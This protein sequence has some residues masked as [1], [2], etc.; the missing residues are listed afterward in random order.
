MLMD[1]YNFIRWI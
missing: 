1:A